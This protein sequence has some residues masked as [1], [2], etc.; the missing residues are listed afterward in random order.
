MSDSYLN[1]LELAPPGVVR[2]SAHDFATAL[3]ETPQFQALEA[4]TECLNHDPAARQILQALEAKQQ[5]LEPL[6]LLNSVSVEERAELEQLR[7]AFVNQPSVAAYFQAQADLKAICQAAA[8]WLSEA[9]GLNYAAA[10]GSGC[11]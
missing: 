5:A 9:I 6:L 7:L 10:C 2:Q 3:A 4:A 11:C 1:E 8:D